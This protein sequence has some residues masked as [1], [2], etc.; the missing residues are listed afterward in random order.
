M[1]STIFAACVARE[2][3]LRGDRVAA[4]VGGAEEAVNG[5]AGEGDLGARFEGLPD[6]VGFEPGGIGLLVFFLGPGLGVADGGDGGGLGGAFGGGDA[7]GSGR[8]ADG[9]AG[10]GEDV[11]GLLGE[12]VAGG[13]ER[14]LAVEV[15]GGNLAGQGEVGVE[16]GDGGVDDFFVGLE[17]LDAG[18]FD[19][20]AGFAGLGGVPAA[21]GVWGGIGHGLGVF[22]VLVLGRVL[23]GWKRRDDRA[24]DAEAATGKGGARGF[25]EAERLGRRGKHGGIPG[26]NSGAGAP[27]GEVLFLSIFEDRKRL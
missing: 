19:R 10:E 26:Q 15:M 4:V 1:Y 22:L 2:G 12:G 8:F 27:G 7:V 6:E 17:L 11:A 25:D 21:A 23:A 20:A 13:G 18:A 24:G 3:V 14:V 9:R 5:G 16:F